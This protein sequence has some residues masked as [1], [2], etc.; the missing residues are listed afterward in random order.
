MTTAA[1]FAFSNL[2]R[3]AVVDARGAHNRYPVH[4]YGPL[5]LKDIK[6][7]EEIYIPYFSEKLK[8]AV[9]QKN[10]QMIQLYIRVLGNIAYPTIVAVFEPYIEGR[11]EHQLT[12]LQ[13]TLLVVSLRKLATT[14][15]KLSQSV[16]FKIYDNK[17]ENYQVRVAAVYNLMES[18]PPVDVLQRIA[19]DAHTE[20]SQQV[21]SAIKTSIETSSR[22]NGKWN[23]ER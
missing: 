12:T 17:K 7:V 11:V 23:N 15:P 6:S 18:N 1:A 8:Q 4:T 21:R 3:K 20:R 13:R 10:S 16:L 22:L 2:V 9:N 14:Y 5:A 19:M